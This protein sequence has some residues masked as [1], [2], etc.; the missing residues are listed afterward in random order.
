MHRKKA[1]TN[2]TVAPY[3]IR[4]QWM[5]VGCLCIMRWC[6]NIATDIYLH[7]FICLFARVRVRTCVCLCTRVFIFSL[8]LFHFVHLIFPMQIT[9]NENERYYTIPLQT[10]ALF[11]RNH[12]EWYKHLCMQLIF[13][14]LFRCLR[15]GNWNWNDIWHSMIQ[16]FYRALVLN[17][18]FSDIYAIIAC[19]WFF[20]LWP[21]RWIINRPVLDHHTWQFVE[22][23][24]KWQL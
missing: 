18:G 24:N 2:A 14:D 16:F 1:T 21:N 20:K 17:A 23:I 4:L 12:S 11:Q 13:L 19:Y 3:R 9:Y 6:T 8:Y 22:N 5:A 15:I 10:N 7:L